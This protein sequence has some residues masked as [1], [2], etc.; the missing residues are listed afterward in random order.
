MTFFQKIFPG[1]TADFDIKQIKNELWKKLSTPC[2]KRCTEFTVNRFRFPVYRCTK[3]R[4]TKAHVPRKFRDHYVRP[5]T[6]QSLGI[7]NSRLIIGTS[8]RGDFTTITFINGFILSAAEMVQ[9][10]LPVY[11]YRHSAVHQRPP[12]SAASSIAVPSP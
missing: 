8:M 11:A 2:V 4:Q 5:L 1:S 7:W 6:F 12:D 10:S 9:P 3:N